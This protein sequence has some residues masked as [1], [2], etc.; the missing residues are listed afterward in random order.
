MFELTRYLLYRILPV[1]A[2]CAFV[3]GCAT[4]ESGVVWGPE[5]IAY[6]AAE[7]GYIQRVEQYDD[8]DVCR[9]TLIYS[10]SGKLTLMQ[11]RDES[12]VCRR[13]TYYNDAGRV[14]QVIERD[15]NGDLLETI[16]FNASG[17]PL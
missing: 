5:R 15:A 11:E 13:A 8:E 16:K 17:T 10:E 12:G 1:V 14:V 4:L 6:R 2:I 9:R 7:P 3:F